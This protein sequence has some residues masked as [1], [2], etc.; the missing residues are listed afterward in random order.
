MITK[1]LI[2][3]ALAASFVLAPQQGTLL[4]HELKENTTETYK[5]ATVIKQTMTI[6]SM[7]DQDVDMKS[8]MNYAVKIN[9]V[10]ATTGLAQ[11]D[12]IFSDMKTEADGMVGQM[13]QG[14]QD[15]APKEIKTTGTLDARNRFTVTKKPASSSAQ[16]MLEQLNP[17]SSI[18]FIELPEKAVA[19]GDTW[20]FDLPK[21]PL[22]GKD[23]QK[24]TAK[25]TGERDGDWVVA[26]TGT[27]KLDAD[28][29]EIM[30]NMPN[31]P[32]GGAQTTLT[33]TAALKGEALIDKASGKMMS[34]VVDATSKTTVNLPEQG[35]NIDTAG[36]VKTVMTL[37]K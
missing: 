8:S 10:D 4:R 12:T 6:P 27:I 30:K 3:A 9:K 13:M 33:G 21:S 1:T 5:V 11:V 2:L 7:G 37:Q 19:V 23:Q 28:L 34:Y 16:M 18:V 20:T 36:T 24:L 32:L 29:T 31:N 14:E 17:T 26:I 15:Q 35:I 22:F 25:L